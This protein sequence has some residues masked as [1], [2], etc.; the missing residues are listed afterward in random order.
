MFLVKSVGYMKLCQ[1]PSSHYLLLATATLATFYKILNRSALA[2]PLLRQVVNT[3]GQF[4]LSV[5]YMYSLFDIFP[6]LYTTRYQLYTGYSCP[7]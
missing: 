2:I 7:A 5:Y 3:V 4:T 1:T 6:F